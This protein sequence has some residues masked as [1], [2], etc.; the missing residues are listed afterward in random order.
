MVRKRSMYPL[1]KILRKIVKSHGLEGSATLSTLKRKWGSIM[2]QTIAV[3]TFP[4][5]VRNNV[6]TIVVDTPQWM[7]HLSFYKE[8]MAA[9]L[10]LYN[11][12]GIR[13]RIGRITAGTAKTVTT[14]NVELTDDE[15]KYLEKVTRN[16]RDVELKKKLQ[17]LITHGLTKGKRKASK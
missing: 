12:D 3:H 4:E 7:H 17:S 6:L 11:I 16:I 9:K 13:F 5:T 2:G 15:S 14:E 10:K 8:D 1:H